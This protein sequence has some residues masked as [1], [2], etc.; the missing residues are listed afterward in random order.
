MD[1]KELLLN[2]L[3]NSLGNRLTKLEKKN[4]EEESSLKLIKTSFDGFKKK[5]QI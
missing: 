4:N 1:N 5:Y 3:K 2:I